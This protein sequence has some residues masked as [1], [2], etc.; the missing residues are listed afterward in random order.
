MHQDPH[1]VLTN[2]E[3]PRAVFLQEVIAR[4]VAL[5]QQREEEQVPELEEEEGGAS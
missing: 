3:K 5:L 4:L 1:S 2:G